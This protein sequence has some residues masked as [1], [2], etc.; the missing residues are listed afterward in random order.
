LLATSIQTLTE[1]TKWEIPPCRTAC[2]AGIN[3]QAY[4]TLISQR[5][6]REALEVIRRYIP[7]PSVC[8]RVYFAPCEDACI[9]SK[10]D[11]AVGIRVLKRFV[12]DYEL[13]IAKTEKP[14]PVPKIHEE[15]VAVIGSGPAGLTTAYE[16]AKIGYPVT[17]FEKSS[18]PGGMLRECIPKYRLPKDILDIEI[19]QI[20]SIGI[21]IRTNTE[22]GK[23]VT[24]EELAKQGY[25]A[26]FLAIGAQKS[27][28]LNI[29]GSEF[30]M[31]VDT[32]IIA[33]GRTPNPIIQQ[34]TEGLEVT[35]WGTIV[36]DENGKTSIQGV[37]A[38]GDI[39]TGAATVI[40]AMGAGKKAAKAIHQYL[41][42]KEKPNKST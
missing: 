19:D 34:T 22:I 27:M 18:K 42:K 21:E 4:V 12:A 24:I 11:E 29:E 10:V 26:V 3:I 2:P 40:S 23:D 37:Y 32:V 36:T 33:I 17:V 41:M 1:K 15:K 39:V 6:F 35:K 7:F 28:K 13:A 8:G 38:G 31:D 9:R 14:K 20:K 16:L 25:N 30:T 5:K